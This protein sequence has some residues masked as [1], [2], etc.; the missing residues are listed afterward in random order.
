LLAS[1]DVGWGKAFERQF[2]IASGAERYNNQV[3]RHRLPD[4][5]TGQRN[6][7]D[8]DKSFLMTKIAVWNP[9]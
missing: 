1:G 4:G 8:D 3:A 6:I 9:S 5:T 7:M 2:T